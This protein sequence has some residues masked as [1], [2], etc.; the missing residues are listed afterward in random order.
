M[1]I[2]EFS[3]RCGLSAHTLRYYEKLGLIDNVSRS[4]SGHRMHS[5]ADTEWVRFINRLK[6]TGMPLKQILQY[7]ELRRAGESTY[8]ARQA[9][10]TEHRDA[11]EQQLARQRDHLTALNNKI[12][13]YDAN[14]P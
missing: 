6:E 9:L 5:K 3:A 14:R 4:G 2:S 1:N 11:L 7:A 10:L 13:F 8:C 12:A